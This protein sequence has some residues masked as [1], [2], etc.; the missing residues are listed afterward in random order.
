MIKDAVVVADEHHL[1]GGGAAVDAQIGVAA[2]PGNVPE[3][4]AEPWRDAAVNCPVFLIIG[5]QRGQIAVAGKVVGGAFDPGDQFF[6]RL[7]LPLDP[8]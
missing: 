3:G 6:D 1:G 7:R 4:H 5:K 8:A 2:I